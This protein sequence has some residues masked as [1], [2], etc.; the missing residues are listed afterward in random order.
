MPSPS[1]RRSIPA[2][3]R[4]TDCLSFDHDDVFAHLYAPTYDVFAQN[5]PQKDLYDVSPPQRCFHPSPRIRIEPPDTPPI[6]PVSNFHSSDQDD[7]FSPSSRCD[8]DPG[9]NTRS[10]CSEPASAHSP[11]FA[12][13]HQL[14]PL[15]ARSYKLLDELGSGGYGFV[16]T[17]LQRASGL[18]CAV[19]FILKDKVPEHSWMEDGNGRRIPSEIMLL[20]AINHPNIV[21]YIDTFED[22]L[23]FYLVQEL[24]GSP[25]NKRHSPSPPIS[26]SSSLPSLSPSVSTDSITLSEPATPPPSVYDT[27]QQVM[28]SAEDSQTKRQPLPL[29]LPV[30]RPEYSR[31]PSHDL[32][33]CIEQ[34]EHKRLSENQAR[35]VLK[36]VVEAAYYLDINGATHRDIKDENIVID[37][38]LRVK[39]I[40]FGSSVVE[41]DPR[42]YHT[43]FYG[44]TC[45][46]SPEILQKRPYQDAIQGRMILTDCPNVS[47]AA[48][49]LMSVCLD[50]DV[51]RRATIEQVRAHPWLR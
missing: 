22:P 7:A 1:T 37:E 6:S 43:L 32:F 8:S 35:Y 45:Y 10:W 20:R 39:L 13:E 28:R 17:C 41:E 21:A 34:S 44:T 30:P 24:H 38:T 33:E 16:M 48:L 25:W 36:Q 46:A 4:E 49:D 19:K 12:P 51:N 18:E 40:D 9:P 23:Y 29:C 26:P 15:F 2:L 27:H 50:P 11:R 31:R 3:A 5:L 14:D 42:P 47:R